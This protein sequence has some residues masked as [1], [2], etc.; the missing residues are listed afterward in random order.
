M[1]DTD[2]VQLFALDARAHGIDILP[3][4][5]N[6]SNFRFEPVSEKA[7]RYGLG[8]IKG[9]GEAAI[10]SILEAR[11]EGLFSNLFDFCRR[12]DKRLVNRRVVESLVRAGAFDSLNTHRAGLM[13]AVGIALESAEQASRM[14]HQVSLFGELS[15]SATPVVPVDVPSTWMADGTTSL[16][17]GTLA[18]LVG[19]RA[20]AERKAGARLLLHRA[21]V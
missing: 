9:T 14:A 5:V 4:D 1:D 8:G 12:V 6:Q 7:V 17:G 19:E 18:A 2:K 11:K 21:P 13:A 15:E 20:A 16:Y 3:P 10:N